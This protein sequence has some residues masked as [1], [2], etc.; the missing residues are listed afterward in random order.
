MA[1]R[2]PPIDGRRV[3]VVGTGASAMQL[4]RTVADRAAHVTVFQRSPQWVRPNPDYHREV[5]PGTQWLL[6]HVPG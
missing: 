5:A 3:A 4:L 6:E 2:A 1:R